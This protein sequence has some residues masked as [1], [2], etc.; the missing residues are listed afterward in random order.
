MKTLS[1]LEIDSNIINQWIETIGLY[2]HPEHSAIIGESVFGSISHNLIKENL[3]VDSTVIGKISDKYFQGLL[4]TRKYRVKEAYQLFEQAD[5]ELNSQQLSPQSVNFIN[6]FALPAKAY[7]CYK[8]NEFQFAK[9]YLIEAIK[10]DEFL[11]NDGFSILHYHRI[12]Q[13][14]N[15]S[16][17]S[18]KKNENQEA[19][20]IAKEIIDYLCL[21]YSPKLIGQWNN[22]VLQKHPVSL[23]SA[24]LY[25]VISET[26]SNILRIHWAAQH[27]VI[28]TIIKTFENLVHF[29]TSTQ[30]ET[31]MKNWIEVIISINESNDFKDILDIT[32][33]FFKES[34][35][36]FD[37]FKLA[38]I[39]QLLAKHRHHFNQTAIESLQSII[40]TFKIP[41]I[42]KQLF[43][44]YS[45]N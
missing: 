30:D 39:Q 24:M 21:G 11:E 5:T 36:N 12:Q 17:M 22:E 34:N 32:N 1:T 28:P 20:D 45:L 43:T 26:L 35:H 25:Q 31:T 23:R 13:L 27:Q 29:D 16:R 41:E 19:L 40:N 18:F 42:W 8:I 44:K 15:L 7:L 14:H 9:T 10:V 33:V 3:N 4:L 38:I 6:S 37:V 2:E